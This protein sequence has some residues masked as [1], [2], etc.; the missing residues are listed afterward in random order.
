VPEIPDLE[1]YL[2]HLRR[3][4]VGH[5]LVRA[6]I[7]SVFLV[8]TFD[9]PVRALEGKRVVGLRRIG[10]R[11]GFDFEDDLHLVLHLMI[12]GRLRWRPPDAKVPGK[13]GLA[14]FDFPE[15]TLLLTEASPKKRASLHVVRGLEAVRAIDPGGIEPMTADLPAFREAL[16]RENHTVK[17]ALTDPH[18]FAGIGN[19]YSDEILWRARLSPVRLTRALTDE[20]IARLRDATLVTLREWI[21]RLAKETGDGFPE[22]VTAFHDAMAVH[23]RHKKPCPACGSPVQRIAY[24]ANEANYCA[25]CQTGGKLLADRALSRLLKGDWPKTLEELEERKRGSKLGG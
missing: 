5:P 18:L 9:P 17:R 13:V 14:A 25:R 8:R 15:G 24:A 12:A 1:V 3:R 16:V 6:R 11:I 23:G 7:A 4:V 10:K 20:E 21:D 2:Q 19:A 22:K